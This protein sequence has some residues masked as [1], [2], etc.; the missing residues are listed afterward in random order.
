MIYVF[1]IYSPMQ[2]FVTDYQKQLTTVTI[3]NPDLLSQVRKVLRA[4]IGDSIWIQSPENEHT[5]TRYEVRIDRWDNKQV[6]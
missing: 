4:N 6:E 2:L 1:Y 3:S 5:K